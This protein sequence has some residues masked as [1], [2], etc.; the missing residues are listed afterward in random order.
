MC[1]WGAPGFTVAQLADRGVRRISVGS[2]LARVGWGAYLRAARE[3][4][5]TGTFESLGDAVPTPEP[6]AIFTRP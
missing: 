6:S 5:D 4:H 1:S 2:A 3:I